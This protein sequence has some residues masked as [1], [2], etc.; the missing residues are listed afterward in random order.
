MNN[1]TKK[2]G[3]GWRWLLGITFGII[4]VLLLFLC[5]NNSS[6]QFHHKVTNLFYSWVDEK[7]NSVSLA[8]FSVRENSANQSYRIY[9]TVDNQESNQVISYYAR[10]MYTDIY[11]NGELVSK[12]EIV[13]SPY[14]GTSPGVRWHIISVPV[15]DSTT[16]ICLECVPVYANSPG[17]INDIY[18]GEYRAVYSKTIANHFFAF[19]FGIFFIFVGYIFLVLFL[20]M[21]IKYHTGADFAYL[22]CACIFSAIWTSCESL[23][24]QLFF[25]NTALFHTITYLALIS[26]APSFS[27]IAYYMLTGNYKKITVG[28][29]IIS[30]LNIL[31]T[32]FLHFSG[33][34]EYHYTLISTHILIILFFPIAVKLI[35]SYLKE[36]ETEFSISPV[37]CI[38]VL[39]GCLFS[40]LY[41]Y[42][43]QNYSDFS[44]YFRIAII[45]FLFCLITYHTNGVMNKIRIGTKAKMLHKLAITD[46]MTDFYN[47]RGFSEHESA[48]KSANTGLASVGI[49]MLDVN[50]LK[51]VNDTLG[52]EKGDQLI[53]LAAKAIQKAFSD[54]GECY[55]I[56]GDEFLVVLKGEDPDVDFEIA[57]EDFEQICEEYAEDSSIPFPVVVACGFAYN[58][59]ISLEEL[60][61]QADKNM[62]KNK[63]ERKNDRN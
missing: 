29:S 55:R 61:E 45:S 34:L 49:A 60:I 56:G 50:N 19:I 54:F 18:F 23:L 28:Y 51:Q 24:W 9:Y 36:N 58:L 39:I 26:L 20:V 8:D 44:L 10:N 35:Q 42:I 59:N 27:L 6:V 62:Y 11:I 12:D 32:T 63:E 41:H 57:V 1:I 52:H 47:R 25:G 46:S 4:I 3:Q 22:G 48:Y 43:T 53:I 37:L 31:A 17:Y 14:L 38:T 13:S 30:C 15:S 7:G 16:Q 2:I 33:I 5:L 40:A 21:R